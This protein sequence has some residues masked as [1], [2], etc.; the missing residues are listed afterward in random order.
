MITNI[1]TFIGLIDKDEPVKAVIPTHRMRK[2]VLG[3]DITLERKW[4]NDARA[5]E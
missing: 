1:L 4:N 2:A 5:F 3:D